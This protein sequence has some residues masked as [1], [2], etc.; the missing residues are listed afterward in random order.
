MVPSFM[1]CLS[2]ENTMPMHIIRREKNTAPSYHQECVKAFG[3]KRE[4]DRKENPMGKSAMS[5]FPTLSLYGYATR[6]EIRHRVFSLRVLFFFCY[7]T[8]RLFFQCL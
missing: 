2:F 5:C 7:V 1:F 6:G 4:K 3:K 8:K